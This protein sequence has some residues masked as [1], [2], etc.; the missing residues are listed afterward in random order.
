L[1][2]D[3]AFEA[4]KRRRGAHPPARRFPVAEVVVL[5]ALGDRVE[6]VALLAGAELADTQH[7]SSQRVDATGGAVSCIDDASVCQ[8]FRVV[9]RG[10]KRREV[11]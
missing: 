8:K 5:D 6:V 1:R 3:F 7:G 11:R 9:I 10:G 4:E 2:V